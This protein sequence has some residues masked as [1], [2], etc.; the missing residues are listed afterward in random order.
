MATKGTL[1]TC[2]K[3]HQFYKSSNCP[4]CPV[5]EKEKKAPASFL[6][7]MGA[8]ARRALENIGIKTLKQLAEYSE[9]DLLKQHGFGPASLPGLRK[10][11]EEAGLHFK[12]K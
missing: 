10:A 7:S 11:L 2:P 9:K 1:K 12:E 5:C 6:E 8:P 3:G 4:A